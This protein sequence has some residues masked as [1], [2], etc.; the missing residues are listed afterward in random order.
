MFS[1]FLISPCVL[2]LI[3]CTPLWLAGHIY[4]LFT[5]AHHTTLFSNSLPLK[6]GCGLERD[7]VCPVRSKY[8]SY[9]SCVDESWGGGGLMLGGGV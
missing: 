9:F 4:N 2:D 1:R 3:G 6:G 5:T 7:K 8:F